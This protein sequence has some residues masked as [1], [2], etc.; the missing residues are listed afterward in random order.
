M[1][2]IRAITIRNPSAGVNRS[3]EFQQQE[4]FTTADALNFWPTDAKNKRHRPALR[5]RLV[6]F[7]SS[8]GTAIRSLAAISIATGQTLDRAL[9]CISNG[10]LYRYIAGTWTSVSGGSGFATTRYIPAADLFKNLYIADGGTNCRV[11]DSDAN[12]VT[13]LTAAVDKGT[14][15]LNCRLVGTFLERIILADDPAYPNRIN[16][17]RA[18]VDDDWQYGLT[19][20]GAAFASS[21]INRPIKAFLAHDHE[22]LLIGGPSH[23]HVLRGDPMDGGQFAMLSDEWGPLG[24]QSWC[25]LGDGRTAILGRNGISFMPPGCGDALTPY[26][27]RK[28]PD[29]LMGIDTATYEPFLAFDD[30]FN[31]LGIYLTGAASRDAWWLDLDLGGFWPM[32]LTSNEQPRSTLRV[33]SLD[34]TDVSGTLLGGAGGTIARFDR[35]SAANTIASAKM[36][37]GPIR[38]SPTLFHKSKILA[39]SIKFSANTTDTTG[40]VKVYTG[41]S[42]EECYTAYVADDTARRAIYSVLECQNNQRLAPGLGGHAMMISI[43]MADSTKHVCIEEIT[44]VVADAGEQN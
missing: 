8:P 42:S 18:A 1:A 32:Q 12:S 36:V 5:P 44:V 11:Y 27:R 38:I 17:G 33:D 29:S 13:N 24:P 14:A 34:G 30:A 25:K 35:S 21:D 15:P 7:G 10:Q 40:V 41:Q 16:F 19:D 9:L 26:S 4:P 28:I 31:G 20:A 43:A 2:K 3:A 22:C 39:L 37:Y 23:T 6:A